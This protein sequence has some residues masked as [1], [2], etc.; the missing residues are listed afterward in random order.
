[1]IYAVHD[2]SPIHH[3]MVGGPPV[4]PYATYDASTQS[5]LTSA[6]NQLGIRVSVPKKTLQRRSGFKECSC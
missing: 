6:P 3:A 1:M 4:I 5:T 2:S